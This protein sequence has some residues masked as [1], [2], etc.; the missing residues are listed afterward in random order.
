[1]L[2][3]KMRERDVDDNDERERDVNDKDERE[4]QSIKMTRQ[5]Y[6]IPSMLPRP[7]IRI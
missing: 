3:I 5:F 1:M 2:T 4:M 7:W 6:K